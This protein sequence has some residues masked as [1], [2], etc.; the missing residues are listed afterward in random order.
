MLFCGSVKEVCTLC[1]EF[2]QLNVF[3]IVMASCITS[4]L[5]CNPFNKSGHNS[6][7][8]DIN[9]L[10]RMT[11]KLPQLNTDHKV[12]DKYHKKIS[13]LSM[14]DQID[15]NMIVTMTRLRILPRSVQ[16]SPQMKVCYQLLTHPSDRK[17]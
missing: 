1:F 12:C 15:K 4:T 6:M 2:C 8:N 17:D 11:E 16:W 9:I 7:R 5:C 13:K 14:M 3:R 10:L